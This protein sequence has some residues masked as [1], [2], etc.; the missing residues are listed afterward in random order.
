MT[1]REGG[2]RRPLIGTGLEEEATFEYD[3]REYPW[4]EVI[5][6]ILEVEGMPLEELHKTEEAKLHL[7]EAGDK[8]FQQGWG[9]GRRANPF[10]RKWK[11][12]WSRD[13]TVQDPRT[14]RFNDLLHRFVR[15]FI[16]PRMGNETIIY[17]REPTLRVVFPSPFVPGKRHTDSEYHHQ[18]AEVNW[19][20]P[21]SCRVWG[22]N[23]LWV[24]SEPGKEDFHSL[25]LKYGEV[26]R[27]YGNQCVHYCEPNSTEYTRVSIDL[28]AIPLSKFDP[29]YSH[30][31][32]RV[33]FRLGG[34]Y[35]STHGI[36]GESSRPPHQQRSTAPEAP[37]GIIGSSFPTHY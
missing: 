10:L 33:S 24:E 3:V 17:Q 18:P 30:R 4:R 37:G 25:D 21:V 20:F 9:P 29:L 19:W 22:T 11:T 31:S 13:S 8:E 16:S 32:D 7:L 27:F 14:K 12:F 1:A 6:S 35:L 34:Y 15:D 2:G 5:Q 26:C 28:R 23:S 36:G